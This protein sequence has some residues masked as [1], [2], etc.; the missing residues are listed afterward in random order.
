MKKGKKLEF[1]KFIKINNLEKKPT[2]GGTP[3]IENKT[4]V[5]T[6]KK[7]KLNFKSLKECRV[8]KLKLTYCFKVQKIN[9]SE[10]L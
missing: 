8:L 6:D 2:N 10:I 9:R 3:A 5:I 4:I 7:K 1:N